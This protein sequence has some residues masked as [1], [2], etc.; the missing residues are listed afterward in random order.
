MNKKKIVAITGLVLASVATALLA[1]PLGSN[2][3]LHTV[4]ETALKV[5]AILGLTAPISVMAP[6]SLSGP[7]NQAP[8]EE[9]E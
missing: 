1:S 3:T 5:L 9:T 7:P 6:G 4:C 2:A 8:K